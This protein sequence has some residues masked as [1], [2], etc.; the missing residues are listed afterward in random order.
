MEEVVDSR[1]KKNGAILDRPFFPAQAFPFL[2]FTQLT[3]KWYEYLV[4]L[5]YGRVNRII[6]PPSI[7]KR[8]YV[9]VS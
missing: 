4:P 7:S 2:Q 8:L 1:L 3:L 6:Y 9:C 5:D